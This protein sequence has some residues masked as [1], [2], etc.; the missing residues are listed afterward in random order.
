MEQ[1]VYDRL[2]DSEATV[3]VTTE[4]LLERVPYQELPHLKK[5][6]VVGDIPNKESILIS[7]DEGNG[8][9]T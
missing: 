3:L 2:E 9:C 8:S 7:Y 6:I 1:A 4:E 5:I